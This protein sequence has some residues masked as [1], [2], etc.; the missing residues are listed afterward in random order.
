MIL[1]AFLN[2]LI[3]GL[4]LGDLYKLYS[5]NG[6]H[7]YHPKM[8]LKV[9]L[10]AYMNN[11]YSCR[12]I[13][14][15]LKRDVHFIWLA[16]YEQPDFI[17]INRFR[18]RVK[19]EIDK[20]FTQI[21]LVLAEKGLI[22]LDVEYIDGTKIESK[23]NKYTFVWRKS[24]EKNRAKL[25]KK[26][27][28]LLAQVD[29][30]IAQDN[31]TEQE[32]VEITPAMLTDMTEKLKKSLEEAPESDDNNERKQEIKERKK[33]IKEL[34]KHRD[35]LQEYDDH[36]TN[37]GDR[38]SYSK[39][40]TDATFIHM[41]EDAMR[42]GQTKPGY[43]LQIS[44]ENQFI[45]D[46][47]LYS[48]PTDTLTMPSFLSS[49]KS[50]YGHFAK[51]AV[52]DSG[53]GSQ[54]NY[55]FMDVNDITA[56]V[57][58]N[59]FHKEQRKRYTPNPFHPDNLYYNKEKDY[60]VCPMGQHMER[61]YTTKEISASGFVSYNPVYKAQRCEECPLRG[62]CFKGKGDRTIE[63]NH[64]LQQYKKKARE[65][66]TSEE[67]VKQRGRR[68]IEPEAVFGQIK[69][70]KAYKRFR[71]FGKDKVFMDFAF[72][73]IAFNIEKLCKKASLEDLKAFIDTFFSS[74]LVC[75]IC[76]MASKT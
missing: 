47:A 74:F 24:V 48:N 28:T 50:R 39:T 55:Q 21:I 52:A 61:I 17:T 71:H 2:K 42:N 46:F 66:L 11:I 25:L 49:F 65:L 13:E 76:Y 8:M 38:N 4:K 72:F 1:F 29:D 22:S 62:S 69:S 59:Y 58:Y 5:P 43:N 41:K 27:E 44:T 36:L 45:T 7:S 30:A 31:E 70:N 9:V 64:E 40:D 51:T 10:Y 19:T 35:K 23:A 14:A 53:Y 33:Q 12:R 57:K 56:Y 20:I 60:Y 34:E 37:M 68:C 6:R 16:G 18:N 3:D 26:I 54:E 75:I 63:V 73:A 15:L 67:G 32:N